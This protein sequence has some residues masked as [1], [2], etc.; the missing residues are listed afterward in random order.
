[1]HTKIVSAL[2]LAAGKSTRAGFPK[3]LLHWK[4]ESFVSKVFRSMKASASFR[5]ILVVTGFEN[6]RTES[7]LKAIGADFVYNPAFDTGMHSSIRLGLSVLAPGWQGALISH[8]DQ[9]QLEPADYKTIV[10][11]FQVTAKTLVRPVFKGQ[12]GT[13]A[14]LG[15]EHLPEINAEPDFDGGCAYLFTRHPGDVFHVE[16]ENSRCL[17]DIDFY[18]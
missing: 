7:E 12:A 18:L 5:D 8:V 3:P 1:M 9:P 2:L 6:A 10:R 13:P 16:M 11:A 14:I 15:I 17:E 4:G